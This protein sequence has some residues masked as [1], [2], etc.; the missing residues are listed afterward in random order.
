MTQAA[1]T[2]ARMQKRRQDRVER[3]R[4]QTAAHDREADRASNHSNARNEEPKDG[5]K[6]LSRRSDVRAQE[7]RTARNLGHCPRS[8]DICNNVAT[9]YLDVHSVLGQAAGQ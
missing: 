4:C 2:N 3:N 5:S 7:W 8:D 6:R 1:E 9:S